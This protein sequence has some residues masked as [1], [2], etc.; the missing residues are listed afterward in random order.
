MTA[1]RRSATTGTSS[2]ND[3]YLHETD[4]RAWI[5]HHIAKAAAAGRPHAVCVRVDPALMAA[6]LERNPEHWNRKLSTKLVSRWE[7]V[8]R[9]DAWELNGE[10]VIVA[11]T[12]ELNNG[13]H[14]LTAGIR[15]GK[16]FETFI[17][18]GIERATRGSLDQGKR[19]TLADHLTMSGYTNVTMRSSA[20]AVVIG[21]LTRHVNM[22]GHGHITPNQ[23][24]AAQQD[25]P[26][27]MDAS[28]TAHRVQM[29]FKVS[30]AVV[31]GL[32][33]LFSRRSE[34]GA[35]LFFQ[36]ALYGSGITAKDDPI[37]RLQVF[38][39]DHGMR[40]Q[41]KSRAELVACTIKSWNHYWRGERC[42]PLF[43]RVV[44]RDEPLPMIDEWGEF[45]EAM[46]QKA[47]RK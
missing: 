2:P 46:L 16:P 22:L 7:N 13:Q 39:R 38:L 24:L 40:H 18:F 21:V 33:Y 43:W 4:P 34:A 10:T 8:M 41:R 3:E 19:R 23:V 44:G 32:H 29:A 26:H 45:Q 47:L 12:G 6:L 36:H 27:L 35:D 42:G 14:R 28:G 20:A 1:L 25:H 37:N 31:I 30:A 17:V 11:K 15:A 5:D 9:D